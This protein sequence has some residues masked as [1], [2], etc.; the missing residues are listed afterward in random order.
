MRKAKIASDE[1]EDED[2]NTIAGEHEQQQHQTSPS[3]DSQAHETA[4]ERYAPSHRAIYSPFVYAPDLIKPADPFGIY[5]PG[6]MPEQSQTAPAYPHHVTYQDNDDN[7]EEE[8][9]GG[10]LELLSS[11]GQ[12]FPR[13]SLGEEG[14]AKN[15]EH[16]N[17]PKQTHLV[18]Y[19][20][21]HH[22]T[23]H[24]NTIPLDKK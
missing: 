13:L 21:H 18:T 11:P 16:H 6:T 8:D 15:F 1:D 3:T 7:Y 14:S 9:L 10:L 23:I 5:P 4:W 19:T 17:L 20:K 22:V 12:F 24:R 2:A